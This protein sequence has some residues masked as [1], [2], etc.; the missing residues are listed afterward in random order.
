VPLS[1]EALAVLKEL[2]PLTGEGTYVFPSRFTEDDGKRRP[3]IASTNKAMQ[4]IRDRT[5]I[6]A[7]TVHDF[8]TTF[9]THATRAEKPAHKR[10]PAGLGVAPT[11]ADAVLGHKEAS[12]GFDRYTAEPERYL[13]SEKRD[14]LD[15]WGR[16]VIRAV[17]KKGTQ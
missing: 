2:R 12:L 14:A 13:L 11:I 6:P 7:W 10:D 15:R 3:Y 1:A 9:R 16:F 8:R 4:R 17:N 5:E